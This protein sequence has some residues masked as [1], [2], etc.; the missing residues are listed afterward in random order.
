MLVGGG[1]YID[2][3]VAAVYMEG[4]AFSHDHFNI[5]LE[6]YPLARFAHLNYTNYL[7]LI[8]ESYK[9]EDDLMVWSSIIGEMTYLNSILNYGNIDNTKKLFEFFI[10]DC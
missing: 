4:K 9:N 2:E 1:L 10:C 5:N 7:K 3:D 6:I 8:S